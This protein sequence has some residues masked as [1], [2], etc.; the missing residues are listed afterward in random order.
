V[1]C[2]TQDLFL[3][4]PPLVFDSSRSTVET[5]RGRKGRR[6]EDRRGEEKR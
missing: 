1:F 6:E 3:V 5:G 4:N 2:V